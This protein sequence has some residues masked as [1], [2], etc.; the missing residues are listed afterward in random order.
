MVLYEKISLNFS[1]NFN[2][3]DIT[4]WGE[5]DISGGGGKKDS[6]VLE[7]LSIVYTYFKIEAE[8]ERRLNIICGL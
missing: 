8:L 1:Q 7:K 5:G 6:N 4:S 3:G 2:V